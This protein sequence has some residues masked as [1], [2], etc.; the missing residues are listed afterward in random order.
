MANMAAADPLPYSPSLP[1]LQYARVLA[2][3]NVQKLIT[4][5]AAAAISKLRQSPTE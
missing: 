4:A 5:T 2:A 3:V 1:P